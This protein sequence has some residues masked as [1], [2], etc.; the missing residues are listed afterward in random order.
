MFFSWR[1]KLIN[2]NNIRVKFGPYLTRIVFEILSI[3]SFLCTTPRSVQRSDLARN[4]D[5]AP[6]KKTADTF[7]VNIS[8][9]LKSRLKPEP[10]D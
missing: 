8:Q 10:E 4:D 3:P 9:P 1:V 6:L 2:A 7:T 5:D